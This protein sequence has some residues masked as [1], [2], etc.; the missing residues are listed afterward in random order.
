MEP[1][2]DPTSPVP[3]YHQIAEAIRARIERGDLKAGDSLQPMRQA[4]ERWGVNLHTVRHAYAALARE[5]LLEMRSARGTRVTAEAARMRREP[6]PDAETFVARMVREASDRYGIDADDLAS[7]IAA[8]GGTAR[9]V[10]AVVECSAWQCAAHAD[11][12][13]A[14]WHVDAR[15]WPLTSDAEP[16][17]DVVVSTY[18]H[19]NDIR[20]RWPHLL[21][22]VRFMRI[23]V[24]PAIAEW[25]GDAPA[26]IVVER[27]EPTAE[28]VAADLRTVLGDAVDLRLVVTDDPAAVLAAGDDVPVL[29]PPRVWSDLGDDVRSD[30]RCAVIGYALDE[31]ELDAAARA[32]GWRHAEHSLETRR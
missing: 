4:A 7:M 8:A 1:S 11:E 32:L 26:A 29:Y 18:F 16:E 2:I 3:L 30:P 5:G 25:L 15:P 28:A 21:E 10:V 24:A 31:N 20:R 6:P 22:R 27:D 9:P 12:I 17:G 13:A 23:S 14:R 19:Y